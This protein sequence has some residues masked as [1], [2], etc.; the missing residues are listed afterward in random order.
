MRKATLAANMTPLL[1]AWKAGHMALVSAI[2][3]TA[4]RRAPSRLSHLKKKKITCLF[5]TTGDFMK[6]LHYHLVSFNERT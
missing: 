1:A 6:T 2:A 4:Q 5:I 3:A